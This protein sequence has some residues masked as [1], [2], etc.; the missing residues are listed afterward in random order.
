MLVR[1]VLENE[2]EQFDNLATHPLQSW[3]W[4]NFRQKTGRKVIRL[5]AFED[6]KLKAGYQLTVHPLPKTPYSILYFPKGPKPDKL[7]I[8]ALKDLGQ[9]EK[10]IMVKMEPN[11]KND[12][13]VAEFLLKNDCQVGKPLFTK[14]TFQLNL[15]KNLD[16]IMAKMKPKTRYNIRLSNKHEVKIVEDNSD[17]A[18]DIYL[19][20]L[21][22]TTRRQK[23]YAHTSDY[24]KQMWQSMKPTGMAHLFLAKYQQDIL[25]AYIFFVFN[26]VLYYPYGASSRDQRRVMPLYALFWQAIQFGQQQKCHTFDMWGSLGPNSD[27]NDPW[28]GFHHFKEGFSGNLIEFLGTYDLV[29]NPWLYQL[30]N[31]ADKVRW[32]ILRVKGQN[33]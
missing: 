21:G 19:K 27:Q 24:H 33:F 13:K 6:K 16:E 30:Y 31:L 26:N 8:K 3:A 23:F 2:R 15:E 1:E 4:G 7:M 9:R 5:G 18:F 25:G 14:Y 29:I 11:V 17:Q 20:L 28:F 22:E 32:K 12:P 10:A